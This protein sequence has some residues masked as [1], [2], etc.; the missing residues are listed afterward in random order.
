MNGL[1]NLSDKKIFITG[2]TGGIGSA[3][4]KTFLNQ[5]CDVFFT[6]S[7]EE[8]INKLIAEINPSETQNLRGY[9]CDLSDFE[10]IT[11]T[12]KNAI[13]EMQQVDIII[14]N[15]GTNIDKLFMRMDMTEW[16]KV[17]NINL[18]ANFKLISEFS[19][20]L[21]KQRFGRIIAISSV[22]AHTGNIGQANYCA[23][24]SG[25]EG[26]M[27]CLALEFAKYNITVNTI[28]PGFINTEMTDKIPEDIKKTLLEHIPMKYMGEP[29]DIVNAMAFL[30]SDAA[31]Y[32]T[33]QVL[34]VNGGM[35]MN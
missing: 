2:G 14:C 33:G 20:L 19:R 26:M 1:F 4:V 6:S 11:K 7:S 17:I 27:R 15:A 28:A 22:V 25:L 21:F 18:N 23:S 30:T 3:A 24:K 5:G 9:V 8:K 10:Q 34:H 12:V 31:R 13:A 16:M 32:I 29:Q 35:Y